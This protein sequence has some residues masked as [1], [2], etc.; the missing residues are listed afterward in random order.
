MSSK[1]KKLKPIPVIHRRLYRLLSEK[2]LREANYTCE[3]CGTKKG[4]LYNGKPQRVETHHIMSRNNKNSPLKFDIRNA[5]C[6]C[7]R[8]HKT[9]RRSAHK[10]GLW[11]AKKFTELRPNDAKW[12]LDHTDDQVNL[13]DRKILT[14]IEE[15]LKQK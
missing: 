8:C 3:I 10:H 11:F 4:D 6:L 1:K 13:K 14:K 5:I 9:S 2:C 12:I 15:N 7:T